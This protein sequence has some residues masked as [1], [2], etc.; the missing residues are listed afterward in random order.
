MSFEDFMSD[1]GFSDPQAYMDH[2]MSQA[3]GTY[4]SDAWLPPEP[5]ETTWDVK[6]REERNL[7]SLWCT[8]F[9]AEIF[10]LSGAKLSSPHEETPEEFSNLSELHLGEVAALIRSWRMVESEISYEGRS[11]D[12]VTQWL[13]RMPYVERYQPTEDGKYRSKPTDFEEGLVSGFQSA[14]LVLSSSADEIKYM[15]E[16]WSNNVKDA[17]DSVIDDQK[18]DI[19]Y[20]VQNDDGR[21]DWSDDDHLYNSLW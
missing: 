11:R 5:S 18:L 8:A 7:F 10:H 2:L 19:D 17:I 14:E 12:F 20:N 9:Q 3:E 13:D 4:H 1:D 15:I 16:Y 21:S 6:Q